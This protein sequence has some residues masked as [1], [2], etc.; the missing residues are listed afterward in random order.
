MTSSTFMIG[1][2]SDALRKDIRPWATPEDSFDTLTNA[3]QFRGRIVRKSGYDTLARLSPDGGITFP[4]NPV[5]GLRTQNLPINGVGAQNLIGFDTTT[6]YLYNASTEEFSTL[7]SIMPVVWSGTDSQFF[8]TVNYAG[9]LWAT[10]GKPGFSPSNTTTVPGQDGIRYYGSMNS[11]PTVSIGNTWVNY[12]PPINI[13]ITTGITTYLLGALLIFPYRGYLVFLNTT[14]GTSSLSFNFPNRARWTQIGTPYYSFPVPNTPNLQTVDPLAARDDIF[15][16]GGANDAPINDIIV[17]AGF[18]RDIL[19]VYMQKST[20]RL[21]FVNNS[22]NP[23]VWERINFTL[24]SSCTFSAITFDKGLMAIGSRG[25]VISDA[26]DTIRFDEKIPDEIFKIRQFNNGF[27]RVFGIRTFETKLCYWTYPDDLNPTGIYP[28]KVLVYNYETKNWSYFDDCFTCFGYYN[29]ATNAG[30]T[31]NQLT[32]PWE[33]YGNIT[34]DSSI[35]K[36]GKEN[37]LAG[38]QQGYVLVLETDSSSNGPSLFIQAIT[39]STATTPT[40]ITS[41]NHNLPNGSWV[42]LLDITGTTFADGVS[43]NGQNFKTSLIDQNNFSLNAYE[44]IFPGNASGAS[45]TYNIAF[46]PI[47]PGSV[48]INIGALQFTDNDSDGNLFLV[49]SLTPTGII[50]YSTGLLNLTFSPPIVST[51]VSIRIVSLSP[52]QLL[53]PISTANA[54][55]GGGQIAKI[56][57]YDIQTKIFNFFGDDKRS[58]LS[59]IDFYVDKTQNGQFTVNIFPDS[60]NV[61]V[62]TPLPDNP[63]SNVVL[64]SLNPYQ[65]GDGDETIYRLYCDAIAQTVQ[66][67]LTMSDQQMAVTS[68]NSE[69]LEL[70]SMIITMKR[71]GR[72]V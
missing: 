23:F 65:F 46:L 19:V 34:W 57:N 50:N 40:V 25:I 12:N 15:G 68:I 7:P 26:N 67:Q 16:R 30:I 13:N 60:D 5:M 31:W 42:M 29:Y 39:L 27:Q 43:L 49:G 48:Q 56:S 44:P 17:A 72:L 20:W 62:N 21:R 24:G 47:L 63:Q 11:S 66:F 41:P 9:A 18:I 58:R 55:T 54:Y 36:F 37:I 10:N 70:L 52:A 51:S 64:T 28:D 45:F 4:G 22:Q 59:K 8:W 1:P 53:D 3:Y 38:N 2:I 14:E 6:S 33:S 61:P 71:G 69:D 32:L 35:S